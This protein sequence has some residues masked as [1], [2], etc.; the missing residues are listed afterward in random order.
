MVKIL[1]ADI[2]MDSGLADRRFRT[3]GEIRVIS[4]DPMELDSALS[5]KIDVA[6]VSL[7]TDESVGFELLRITQRWTS[8]T[9]V[10]AVGTDPPARLVAAAFRFGAHDF[11]FRPMKTKSVYTYLYD[12]LFHYNPIPHQTAKR[13]DAYLEE[14]ACDENLSLSQV[15][16]V[17]DL[18]YS[19]VCR[20]LRDHLHTTYSKRLLY[21]RISQAKNLLAQTSHNLASIACEVG[22][23]SNCRLSAGFR[24]MEGLSPR[25]Y[26][27]L[28]ASGNLL[29]PKQK[30][31]GYK[32]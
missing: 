29:A 14:S 24:Q 32:K 4:N 18:S 13:I 15:C 25:R 21:W 30:A 5:G 12:L 10:I 9:K 2:N 8:R 17:F 22:L 26:R 28:I 6:M 1:F 19:Y 11:L 31:L 3:L 7:D 27:Q 23:K 16:D 20:L